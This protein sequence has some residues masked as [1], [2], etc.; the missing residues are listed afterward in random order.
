M[1][2]LRNFLLFL[3]S[4]DATVKFVKNMPISLSVLWKLITLPASLICL[5]VKYYT[6]GTTFT[7]SNTKSSLIKTLVTGIFR[8]I[9]DGLTIEDARFLYTDVNTLLRR[10]SSN[11]GDLPGFGEQYTTREDYFMGESVWLT[12]CLVSK[13]SPILLYF[14]GGCFAMQLGDNQVLAMANFYRAYKETYGVEI[15]V[16][17]VDYSLTCNGYTYPRQIN[18]ANDIYDKLIADGY[19]NII[20]AGDSAGGNLALNTLAYLDLESKRRKR[21]VV[22]PKGTVAI[23]PYLNVSK[24]ENTGSVKRYGGGVDI[25][26]SAMAGYF[27]NIYIDGDEFLNSS[28]MINIELNS[29]KID[30]SNNPAIKGGDLL[31]IFGDHEMLTDEILRWCEKVG[32]TSNNPERIAIDIDGTHIGLF[33]NEVIAYGTISEWKEQYCSNTILRFLHEKY[34]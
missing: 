2:Y 32:L 24:R 20:I 19:T 25:F 27:G 11:F 34:S 21:N 1:G 9:A 26:S 8:H 14:H 12:K 23:S 17:L 18:E 5:T 13:D 33:V 30:W 22:W 16:L 10:L 6:V 29:D 4:R 28:P 7:N 3:F 15:S 31:V